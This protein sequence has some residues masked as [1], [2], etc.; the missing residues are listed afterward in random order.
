M[1]AHRMSISEVFVSFPFLF[2]STRTSVFS[3]LVSPDWDT[4]VVGNNT[5]LSRFAGY[6]GLMAFMGDCIDQ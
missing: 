6:D 2:L 1:P 4:F 3:L 5:I